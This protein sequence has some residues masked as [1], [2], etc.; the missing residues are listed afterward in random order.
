M[1]N[2]PPYIKSL[3]TGNINNN[4]SIAAKTVEPLSTLVRLAIYTYKPM[5][6]KLSI[7][8]YKVSFH[9]PAYLAGIY[10]YINGDN[11]DDIHYLHTP[12]DIACK[13]LLNGD[14][15]QKCPKINTIFTLAKKG[16]NELKKTYSSHHVIGHCI[17]HYLFIIDYYMTKAGLHDENEKQITEKLDHYVS[18]PLSQ[19]EVEKHN[20]MMDIW[21]DDD[22]NLAIEL[23][24]KITTADNNERPCYIRSLELLLLPMDERTKIK[25]GS[26]IIAN[27]Y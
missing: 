1:N 5:G 8:E 4:E 15:M 24:Q 27:E 19:E 10:R 2:L 13:Y 20:K 12:I 21:K 22:I 7:G 3:I 26:K 14:R 16:L 23:L 6:T 9:E 11:K 17:D 18:K 25:N